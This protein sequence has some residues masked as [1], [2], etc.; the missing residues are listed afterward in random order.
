VIW[1]SPH[2][3]E[4]TLHLGRSY[5]ILCTIPPSASLPTPAFR[6][7]PAGLP[8]VGA[9][10]SEESAVWQIQQD[11]LAG[12]VT[13]T[14]G[15]GEALT[16]PDGTSLYSSELL[17]MTASDADPAHARMRTEVVYRLDQD[18]REI[19]AEVSGLMT[20]T[21]TTFELS[22]DLDVTLDGAPFHHSEWAETI[23]RRL[24]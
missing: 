7:E 5:L 16:L 21:E 22:V 13:V 18:S 12:T 1:P 3:G 11:I 20:S 23:P 24:V 9:K 2:A 17:E 6:T 14:T 19:V 4:L 15:S 8:E 10:S